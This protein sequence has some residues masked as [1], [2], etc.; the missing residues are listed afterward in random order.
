[1]KQD[2]A[3]GSSGSASNLSER[4]LAVLVGTL[5]GDGCLAQHG[6]HHRLFVK[7]KS[8]HRALAEFKHEVFREFV[9]MR[10]HEFD[11]RLSGKMYPCVQFVS[12]T[13]SVFT[14]WHRR[15]YRNGRK[16]VPPDIASYLSPL[17]VAVWFM[18]DGAADHA[19]ASFQTHSFRLKEVE[20]LVEVLEERFELAG[21]P[22]K[23]RGGWI[24]YVKARS[25][26]RLREIL[27]PHLLPGFAY[28]LGI[29]DDSEPRRD[30]TLAPDRQVRVMT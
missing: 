28:K 10:L 9:S 7:H 24:V 18:D 6:R 26:G 27:L 11:Q 1:V 14:E 4:Q 3:E 13:S 30:Y 21:N 8:A 25:M 2:N 16:I 19:G 17:A 20:L 5:L 12:R 22:R 15:F 23:N 29:T